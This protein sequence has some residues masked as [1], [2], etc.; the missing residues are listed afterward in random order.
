[1]KPS[2]LSLL[3]IFQFVF[4]QGPADDPNRPEFA[5]VRQS[6]QLVSVRISMGQPIKIFVVGNDEAHLD[7][8]QL[9]L[10]V[11]RLNPPEKTLS[12]SQQKDYF[13]I[14][15]PLEKDTDLEVSTKIK[16]KTET[17][18]FKINPK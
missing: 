8:S 2:I 12:I 14:T 7:L 11:R 1:M 5:Q 6:G 4:A 18:R 10:R 15:E 3:F 9:T 13:T 17:F 16:N